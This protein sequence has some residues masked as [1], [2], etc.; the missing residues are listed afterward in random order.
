[1]QIAATIE[2]FL[3]RN[4]RAEY[5]VAHLIATLAENFSRRFPHFATALLQCGF[6]HPLD[7]SP[8][9]VVLLFPPFLGDDLE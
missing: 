1:V 8:L 3:A 5:F 7:A 4:G 6:A 9:T 2:A